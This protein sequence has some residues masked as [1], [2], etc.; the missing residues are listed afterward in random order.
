MNRTLFVGYGNTL[1]SDDGAGVRAAKELARLV[2]GADLLVR[3][4]LQLELAERIAQYEEVFFLD[5]AATPD[6]EVRALPVVP[7]PSVLN[8]G[9]H[10]CG[11]GA[12]LA[13]CHVLYGRSP[14]R[15]T[16]VTIPGE[17]FDFGETLSAFTLEQ[18]AG[19]VA[20]VRRMIAD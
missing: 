11:P 4:E 7:D 19:A 5:A 2:P 14:E 18:V 13:L 17:T 20:L 6:R 1:R 15:A 12:L 8:T 9:S 10:T 16:L 3:Q